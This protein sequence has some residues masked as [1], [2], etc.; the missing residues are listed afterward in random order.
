MIKE[1]TNF[2]R[3]ILLLRK[4]EIDLACRI[5]ECENSVER[6]AYKKSIS[7]LGTDYQFCLC[8]STCFQTCKQ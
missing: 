3:E 8:L 7:Y 6:E 5:A 4:A 2:I 1:P